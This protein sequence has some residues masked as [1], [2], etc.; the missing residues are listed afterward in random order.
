M[1][2]PADVM[3]DALADLALWFHDVP[4]ALSASEMLVSGCPGA[5]RATLKRAEDALGA[6]YADPANLPREV[7]S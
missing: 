5:L 1:S 4:G 7:A 3:A 6:Y 2:R